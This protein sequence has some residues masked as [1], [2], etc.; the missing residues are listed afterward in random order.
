MGSSKSKET[1]VENTGQVS[2]TVIVSDIKSSVDIKNDEHFVVLC[3]I[4]MVLII[5]LLLYVY[6]KHR[7][8]M[9]KQFQ[10]RSVANIANI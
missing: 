1:D 7:N 2:N 8:S 3:L 6:Y 9:K 10:R 4:L 5:E